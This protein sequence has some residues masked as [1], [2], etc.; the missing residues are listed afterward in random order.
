MLPGGWRGWVGGGEKR[1]RAHYGT[2][3]KPPLARPAA[4]GSD[5]CEPHQLV[6]YPPCNVETK[7]MLSPLWIS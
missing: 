4:G 5:G 3:A 1:D 6:A 7:R 2:L